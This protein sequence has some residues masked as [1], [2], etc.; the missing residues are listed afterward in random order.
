MDII[1]L[2]NCGL[3]SLQCLQQCCLDTSNIQLWFL[4]SVYQSSEFHTTIDKELDKL[5]SSLPVPSFL[6]KFNKLYNKLIHFD[7]VQQYLQQIFLNRY[8]T[9]KSCFRAYFDSDIEFPYHDGNI[10]EDIMA[11]IE[12]YSSDDLS[13]DFILRFQEK[14]LKVFYTQFRDINHTVDHLITTHIIPTLNYIQ[15]YQNIDV[16]K[17]CNRTEIKDI[18]CSNWRTLFRNKFSSIQTMNDTINFLEEVSKIEKTFPYV[19]LDSVRVEM[20]R[21]DKIGIKKWSSWIHNSIIHY[22]MESTMTNDIYTLL[23][24]IHNRND[25]DTF[26]VNYMY[27]LRL[28]MKMLVN[29]DSDHFKSVYNHERS[30]LDAICGTNV[31]EFVMQMKQILVDTLYSHHIN[32][33]FKSNNLILI[34]SSYNGI[35]CEL[36]VPPA[37]QQHTETVQNYGRLFPYRDF[38]INKKQSM[39]RLKDADI[40]ISGSLAV[41]SVLYNICQNDG[42]CDMSHLES[43]M[44]PSDTT[45]HNRCVQDI[46]KYIGILKYNKVLKNNRYV[47]PKNSIILRENIKTSHLDLTIPKEVQINRDMVLMCYVMKCAKYYR[48]KNVLT[49]ERFYQEVCDLLKLFTPSKEE[50]KKSLDKC[51]DRE[52]IKK[53][54]DYFVYF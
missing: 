19:D 40:I 41:M 10:Y 52:L 44:I 4:C 33:H 15:Y 18:I 36:T 49:M 53:E 23:H 46:I 31:M 26:I 45:V 34:D 39:V 12:S 9:N 28:R 38:V 5:F 43:N 27:D 21:N 29:L 30:L 24:F 11:I 48:T 37:L 13:L 3:S 17:R 2:P 8:L 16:L 32:Q 51:I 1:R 42:V 20:W 35:N 7:K 22:Y 47:K 6:Q 25:Y 54:G 14:M 50:F